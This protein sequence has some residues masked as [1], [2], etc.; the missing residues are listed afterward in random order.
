MPQYFVEVSWDNSG[1]FNGA[2][3][4]ISALA[5][6]LTIAR[7]RESEFDETQ[8][9][10]LT[11]RLNNAD[12]RFSPENTATP[13]SASNLVPGRPIRVRAVQSGSSFPL[14]YGYIRRIQPQPQVGDQT[15][16][17][18]EAEDAL[19]WL[20]RA[21]VVVAIQQNIT[22]G[23]AIGQVLDDAG[24]PSA[25]RALD[26]GQ[27]TP[28]F[29]WTRDAYAR[30]EIKGLT[31]SEQGWFYIDRRGFA[32][33]ESRH[34]RLLD[35][36][37]TGS[38]ANLFASFDYDYNDEKIYND[39]RVTAHPRVLAA[40]AILWKLD[41]TPT[42]SPSGTAEFWAVYTSPST[43]EA[44]PALNVA[45]PAATTDYLCNSN[46]SGTGV[47]YTGETSASFTD[48]GETAKIQIATS[49]SVAT[50]LTLLQVRGQ[51]LHAPN[52]VTA[53]AADTPSQQAYFK[54][55]LELDLAWQQDS[56]VAQ[57]FADYLLNRYRQPVSWIAPS[58]A[59]MRSDALMLQMLSRELSDRVTI[60]EAVTGIASGDYF[61][62]RIEHTIDLA[63]KQHVGSWRVEK[64]AAFNYWILNV[65]Q[66]GTDTRLA[67]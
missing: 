65:S 67:Y 38:F 12:R 14:Y 28:K 2:Y 20:G 66:L 31:D 63:G 29:W 7:G 48:F 58:F 4:D 49:A 13:I 17:V 50:Y 10:A 16:C 11:L 33:F 37:S 6:E 36:T 60:T 56:L 23:C 18:V 1:S 51:P 19:N 32:V 62:G 21:Q 35:Q 42:L 8:P 9:G 46:A 61:I 41:D 44:V 15:P 47:D 25:S 26:T 5:S 52:P 27:D 24:F 57:D 34:H 55:T 45:S 40:S 59:A 39:V 64:A 53:K 54:R 3:D 22:T 43:M 30:A